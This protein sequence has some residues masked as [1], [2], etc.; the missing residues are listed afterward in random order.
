M[1]TTPQ[2]YYSKLYLIQDTNKPVIATLLPSDEKT[3]NI[4]LNTRKIETPTYLSIEKDHLAETIYFV[5]DRYYDN[6]D[7]LNTTCVVQ[8]VNPLNE[9]R[10]YAVPFMDIQTFEGK[11]LFPWCIEGEAT[12]AAGNIQYSVKF[13]HTFKDENGNILFD[14]N[15]NTLVAKSKILSGLDTIKN[16]SDYNYLASEIEEALSKIDWLSKQEIE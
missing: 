7:L 9:P 11:I 5:V 10:L 12:K 15:L 1:I 2:D 3:Y 8:Y 6:I 14:F 16:N 13:Y 4:D